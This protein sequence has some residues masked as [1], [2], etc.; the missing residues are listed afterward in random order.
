MEKV[1]KLLGIL[2]IVVDGLRVHEPDADVADTAIAEGIVYALKGK[3]EHVLRLA[4]V[5]PRRSLGV[6]H[7]HVDDD[8]FGLKRLERVG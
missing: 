4:H 8:L 1:A 5:V 3:F 6:E 7:H 2:L